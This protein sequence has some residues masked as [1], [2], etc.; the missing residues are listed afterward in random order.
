ML[1]LPRRSAVASSEGE[2]WEASAIGANLVAVK[3][4]ELS[5]FCRFAERNSAEGREGAEVVWVLEDKVFTGANWPLKRPCIWLTVVLQGASGA[6]RQTTSPR[7]IV[8]WG[9]EGLFCKEVSSRCAG[10]GFSSQELT[11]NRERNGS[12]TSGNVVKG[13][14]AK[15]HEQWRWIAGGRMDSQGA[16][17]GILLFSA[18]CT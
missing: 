4:P 14:C 5:I 11:H 17:A 6:R 12:E 8:T 16:P 13:R 18:T 7:P 15:A 2:S 3:P 1:L 10:R 9:F